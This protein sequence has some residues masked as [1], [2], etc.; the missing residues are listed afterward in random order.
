MSCVVLLAETA[1]R[2]LLE[3]AAAAYIACRSRF[4]NLRCHMQTA[5][6]F[7]ESSSCSV[8]AAQRTDSLS[9]LK[10]SCSLSGKQDSVLPSMPSGLSPPIG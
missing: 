4:S 8:E 3:L 6:C 10:R 2:D 5:S 9:C 7:P 1:L